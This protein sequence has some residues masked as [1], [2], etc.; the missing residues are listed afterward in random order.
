MA[1]GAPSEALTPSEA[2]PDPKP[3][4]IVVTVGVP[5]DP[6]LDL[7]EALAAEIRAIEPEQLV[8]IA[9]KESRKNAE[10]LA[11]LVGF[12]DRDCIVQLDSAHDLEEAFL[13]VNRAIESLQ[14]QGIDHE[15]IAVNFTSGTKM[16]SAG[17]VLSGVIK[18][19]MELRYVVGAESG[20]KK[21]RI[22]R[23]HPG[24]IFALQD[25]RRARNLARA[26]RFKSAQDIL[27]GIDN[28]LLEEGDRQFQEN[29]LLICQAYDY[30]QHF[31]PAQ[32]LA[33]YEKVEFGLSM[34]DLFEMTEERLAKMRDLAAAME[35]GVPGPIVLI[36]LYNNGLRQLRNGDVDDA[37]IR[38]YRAMEMLAQWILLR[39]FDIDTNNVQ[40]R[41][42]PPRDRVAFEALRSIEDGMIRI[43]LRKAFDLLIILE[44]SAGKRYREIEVLRE[45]LAQRTDSILAHGLRPIEMGDPGRVFAAASGL[46]E[47]E[48]EN[49][50]SQCE[51]LQF[52]WVKAASDG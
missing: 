15:E 48:I 27:R 30:W 12:Q 24:A 3:R 1:Q 47:G 34:L 29:L 49:F 22:I 26:M 38:L 20:S 17:A 10:R 35:G 4:A 5:S 13:R 36:D 28:S 8:L 33:I 37:L 21:R 46:F 2:E 43:G 41:R 40:T 45:F 42:I 6:R 31:R 9:S 32:F 19:C 11:E 51:L 16:M 50:A 14:S 23:K 25:L 18:R 44:T 39:D 52:P 7:A